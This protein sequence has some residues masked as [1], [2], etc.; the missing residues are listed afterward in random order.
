MDVKR[1]PSRQAW[2]GEGEGKGG[3]GGEGDHIHHAPCGEGSGMT[4]S[5]QYMDG[6]SCQTRIPRWSA[7]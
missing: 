6:M 2:A 4:W 7:Q 3:R 5:S 1:L